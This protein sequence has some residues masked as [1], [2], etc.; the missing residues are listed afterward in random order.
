MKRTSLRLSS[1]SCLVSP[2]DLDQMTCLARVFNIASESETPQKWVSNG[3]HTGAG[4]SPGV[5]CFFQPKK[6]RENVIDGV[7]LKHGI[8][9]NTWWTMR[10]LSNWQ[11]TLTLAGAWERVEHAFS[12]CS[13]VVALPQSKFTKFC[14][15]SGLFSFYFRHIFQMLDHW[16]SCELEH[17]QFV[18]AASSNRSHDNIIASLIADGTYWKWFC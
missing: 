6:K 7:V 8:Y 18:L 15:K 4:H 12:L 13:I 2:E 10:S 9:L 14:H 16:G 11:E 5:I 3:F 17:H 1:T